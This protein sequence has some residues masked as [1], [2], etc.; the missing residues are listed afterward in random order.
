MRRIL[1]VASALLLVSCSDAVDPVNPPPGQVLAAAPSGDAPQVP[2]F[3]PGV[4]VARFAPG[5]PALDV[6]AAQ[7]ARVI[8]DL[9]LDMRVLSVPVGRER[10][11]V[12]ALSNNP[13]VVFAELSVP[14]LLGI[15]C[16]TA[17]GDCVVP[18]DEYFGRRW[19]LHNDGTI[20]DS[21]GNV[22][23]AQG[24]SPDADMD[25]LEAHDLLGAF[26]QEAV[27]GVVDTGILPSH[28]DLSG[29]L[30]DQYDPFNIDDIA[31]D[32]HGH[33]THVS[34]IILAH[35]DNGVGGAGI[36]YGANVRL[37]M[38]KG[39]GNTI[40]G[41]LCWSPDIASGITWAVDRGAAVINLSLGGDSGSDAERTALQYALA[42]DVLP[43]CA[44]GNDE[45]AVDYPAAFPEC[46]AVSATG[47][48]DTEASYTSFGPE[49]EVS[50]PG[51]DILRSDALDRILST[52]LTGGYAYLSGT[53]MASPQVAGLAGLL[54]AMGVHGAAEKRELI[55]STAD[56]LGV[57]G[58]DPVFGAGR[59]NVWAAVLAA[60]GE[61]PPPPP[62][63]EP[64]V[65][66]FTYTCSDLDCSFTDASTDDGGVVAWLWDFGDGSTSPAKNPSHSFAAA[67]AY[68]VY[69]TVWDA[70]G[71]S[72]VAWE[73]V[74][75]EA[76]P[77]PGE[78]LPPTASFTYACTGLTCQFTDTSTDD[79]GV[80]A[81]LWS[82][83]DGNLSDLQNPTHT[84]A[85]PG[86]YLVELLVEDGE[87]QLD[88]ASQE[89]T[90]TEPP[91]LLTAAGEKIKGLLVVDLAWSGT[92][93]P[94]DLY[95]DGELLAG[96]LDSADPA[97]RDETGQRGKAAFTYWA[98]LAGTD[99]CSEPVSV[100]F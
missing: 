92:V 36:A 1:F 13:Q 35:A 64:P 21:Q 40:I 38:A 78:D 11:V 16:E 8:R 91:P 100:V 26:T 43:V 97:Y 62:D 42:N 17:G 85:E 50:A 93:K 29:R 49:V 3:Q 19:D 25:W 74:S 56:D 7:G 52:W 71:R 94:V 80:V 20:R 44:A 96:A 68:D 30:L 34:G 84:W 69:L 60:G 31:E 79:H 10:T 33:G 27:I 65:A 45:G 37:L 59:I 15:P 95:R 12:A 32:D 75:V 54:H 23:L 77:D 28:E 48:D 86:P 89:V 14:R 88:Y 73:T 83:G 98:C 6:A 87:M 5:A 66:G 18:S 67:G 9:G 82:F 99:N 24:P 39:C 76:P 51:G 70:G 63:E 2:A 81:W 46:M 41:Y 90:V 47:W 55:R 72:D 58:P 53:S 4:V 57:P 61:P 22:I